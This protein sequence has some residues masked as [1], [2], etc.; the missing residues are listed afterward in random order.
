[1]QYIG[2]S[3]H[4]NILA[5]LWYTSLCT[6]TSLFFFCPSDYLSTVFVRLLIFVILA[7]MHSYN[8]LTPKLSLATSIVFP[9]LRPSYK[10]TVVILPSVFP[11]LPNTKL[12]HLLWLFSTE[13]IYVICIFLSQEGSSTF[14]PRLP[15]H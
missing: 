2:A 10:S 7:H 8:F 5:L 14:S 11:V 12:F 1:M 3:C 4:E 13:R 15:R 6:F 9:Y